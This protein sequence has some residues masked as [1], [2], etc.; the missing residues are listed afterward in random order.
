M[1]KYLTLAIGLFAVGLACLHE[2]RTQ[3]LPLLGAGKGTTTVGGGGGVALSATGVKTYTGTAGTTVAY[4]MG[5]SGVISGDT[6]LLGSITFD[7]SGGTTTPSVVTA[8]W[9]L[10]GTNQPMTLKA[11]GTPAGGQGNATFIF[12]RQAPTVGNNTLTFAW[13]GS[14]R[15]F[16]NALSFTNS[17]TT[18]CQNGLKAETTTTVTITSGSGHIVAG[19]GGSSVAFGTLTSA[20]NTCPTGAPTCVVYSDS[21]S[22]SFINAYS[23]IA[24]GAATVAIGSSTAACCN[25]SGVDVAP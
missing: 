14:V 23:E 6:T 7:I 11:D 5:G 8:V 3:T 24:A 22:G 20:G 25:I 21:S 2:G 9:D 10:A 13:V 18:G 17:S 4:A 12:C 15:S 16:T 1:R 19:M